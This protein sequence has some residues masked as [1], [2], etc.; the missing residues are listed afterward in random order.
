MHG[1]PSVGRILVAVILTLFFPGAG[2]LSLGMKKRAFLWL[3][4]MGVLV[5]LAPLSVW[6]LVLASLGCRLGALAHLMV[7]FKTVRWTPSFANVLFMLVAFS[8]L[9]VG[10]TTFARV[11]ATEGFRASSNAME[12]NLRVG[13]HFMVSKYDASPRLGDVVVFSYPCNPQKDFVKRVVAL[14]GDLVEVRCDQLYVNGEAVP[15]K[16]VGG[17][18]SVQDLDVHTGVIVEHSCAR[19]EETLGGKSFEVIQSGPSSRREPGML[20]F[21]EALPSCMEAM[22]RKGKAISKPGT[23]VSKGSP[24]NDVCEPYQSY[25]VPEGH[26]FA[27]GDNR[28]NSSDSRVWGAIPNHAIKGRAAYIWFSKLGEKIDWQ[29]FGS[30]I[31]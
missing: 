30:V 11:Y 22:D 5:F 2:H 23:L 27:L 12:P 29:R 3:S 13:E 4:I 25:K 31:D 28:D 20:D 17:T 10:M 7:A 15:R 21:P 16:E 14:Q 18:C 8:F 9:N 19:Y 1:R 24:S 26:F 6:F